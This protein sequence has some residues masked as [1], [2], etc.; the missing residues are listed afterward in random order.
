MPNGA[1]TPAITPTS[2]SPIKVDLPAQEKVGTEKTDLVTQKVI[3]QKQSNTHSISALSLQ[4]I[5]RKKEL[6]ASLQKHTKTTEELPQDE[7]VVD[8]LL[9]HWNYFAEKFYTTGRML[10]ASIMRMSAPVLE[11]STITLELPNE[12]SKLSFDENK[13]DLI[14]GLRKKLNN[15]AL[16]VIVVVNEEI[17]IKKAFTIEDKYQVLLQKNEVLDLLRKTF[18]LDLKL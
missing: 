2:E 9:A 13:Y 6:E 15:Y 12:G 5:K 14:N 18:D 16:D 4:S 8:E 7:I 1:P 11:G 3:L 17:E 10:M